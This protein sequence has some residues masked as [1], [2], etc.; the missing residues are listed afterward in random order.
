M[1]RYDEYLD[2][3]QFLFGAMIISF[4]SGLFM[5]NFWLIALGGLI[6]YSLGLVQLF[7]G[8]WLLKNLEK[9][10]G[11]FPWAIGFYWAVVV[12]YLLNWLVEV[13]ELD[14][15]WRL[16][17]IPL[18]MAIYQYILVWFLKLNLQRRLNKAQ[19]FILMG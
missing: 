18:L 12:I 15:L 13:R 17:V 16:Y 11:W 4:I 1:K 3:H 6:F 10:P 7:Y 9:K 14:Q 5:F 2:T 8:L 19:F